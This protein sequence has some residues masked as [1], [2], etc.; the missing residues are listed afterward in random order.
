M[1]AGRFAQLREH[2]EGALGME[3]GDPHV[4]GAGTGDFVDHPHTGLLQLRN[5]VLEARDGEGD[6]VPSL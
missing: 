3:E 1:L 4:V 2:A 6:V 5:P